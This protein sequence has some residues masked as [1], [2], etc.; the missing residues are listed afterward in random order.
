M[1]EILG[2]GST[3]HSGGSASRAMSKEHLEVPVRSW[4]LPEVYTEPWNMTKEVRD[5]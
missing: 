3:L 2:L 4:D 1:E 5:T